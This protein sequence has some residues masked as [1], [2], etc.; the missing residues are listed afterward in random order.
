MQDAVD[1]D[2]EGRCSFCSGPASGGGKAKLLLYSR[3]RLVAVCGKCIESH[4]ELL[5]HVEQR[6]RDGNA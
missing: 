1:A 3:D 6:R 4:A 2:P 5:R